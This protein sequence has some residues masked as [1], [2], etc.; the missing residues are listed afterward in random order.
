MAMCC[1]GPPT[2]LKRTLEGL[3]T[4][5]NAHMCLQVA[6][7]RELLV[8]TFLWT[9]EGFEASLHKDKMIRNLLG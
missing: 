6:L 2:V 5:V 4:I 9:Y 1:K 3:F 7:F 8:T